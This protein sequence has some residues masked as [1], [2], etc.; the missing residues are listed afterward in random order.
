VR[1]I[2]DTA[3]SL[4]YTRLFELD[5]ALQHLFHGDMREQGRK[6]MGMLAFVIGNLDRP[7]TLL[8]AVS[9]LAERHQAYGVQ[10][11]H[12]QTVGVALLWTLE[13]GLGDAF[14]VEVREAWTAA[15]QILSEVMLA[16]EPVAA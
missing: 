1:P 6:L 11:G 10:S 9:A 13:R 8:P 7:D 3:A 12:Y 15:Y 2:A 4:F 16:A 14:T 5:P